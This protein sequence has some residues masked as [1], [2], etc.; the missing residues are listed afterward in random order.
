MERKFSQLEVRSAKPKSDRSGME[1]WSTGATLA[2]VR[3]LASV[4]GCS[5]EGPN[6]CSNCI[7]KSSSSVVGID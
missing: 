6:S 1:N 3:S 2:S 4:A 7:M 5:S